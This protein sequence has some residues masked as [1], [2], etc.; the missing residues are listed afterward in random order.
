MFSIIALVLASFGISLLLTPLVRRASERAGLLDQPGAARKLHL[1]PTPRTGGVAIAAAYVAALGLLL[2]SPLNGRDA[3]DLPLAFRMLPSV[4]MVFTLGLIDD[5]RGLNAWQKLFGQT[6]AAVMAYNSGIEVN[7]FA[8][9]TTHGWWTLVITVGWL[10]ACSNAFNLI[11]GMDGLA[12]GVGLFA[13]LT[14]LAAALVQGNTALAIAT[15]PL[16]GALLGFLRYNFNPASIFMGDCGSLTVGFMLGCFAAL[17]SQKSATLLGMTAPLMALSVPLL[18]TGAS[19]VR[20]FLRGQPI[21]SPDRNHLHHRLLERGMSTR[22]AALIVYGVCGVAA[23]FSL[24]MSWPHNTLHGLLLLIFCL[25]AW[26]GMRIAGYV[27]FDTA[28]H[29]VMTGTFRHIVNARLF[30]DD[31]ERRA[32]AA[33]D[34][35]GYWAL[36]REVSTEFDLPYAR[37]SLDGRVFEHHRSELPGEHCAT[38]RIPLDGV[39]YVNFRYPVAASVRHAVAITS[40]VAILQRCI[41]AREVAASA[42]NRSAQLEAGDDRRFPTR[43]EPVMVS[44]LLASSPHAN[45]HTLK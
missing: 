44:N 14:T 12:T 26:I 11:D 42:T 10:L 38:M 20:R 22:Q 8:G 39:G 27:E 33:D 35:D 24:L 7:G 17:W 30:M 4:L 9:Y 18:D 19:I 28:R 37:M 43:A 36:V 13:S 29:L 31:F 3:V 23:M 6:I 5:I 1:N 41:V 21:F 16:V 32:A 15:A 25:I 40:V 34:A 45:L 2:L